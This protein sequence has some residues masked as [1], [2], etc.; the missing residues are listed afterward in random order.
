MVDDESKKI[1]LDIFIVTNLDQVSVFEGVLPMYPDI[2][3]VQYF[4]DGDDK[5]L[6]IAQRALLSMNCKLMTVILNAVHRMPNY[7]S[8]GGLIAHAGAK[9]NSPQHDHYKSNFVEMMNL[10]LPYSEIDLS[11]I[12]KLAYNTHNIVAFDVMNGLEDK[13]NTYVQNEQMAAM[14]HSI[15][16]SGVDFNLVDDLMSM[17]NNIYHKS[18]LS[19]STISQND[20]IMPGDLQI[21]QKNSS[22]HGEFEG[23][24]SES[25]DSGQS[26]T[27]D[28]NNDNISNNQKLSMPS[29]ARLCIDNSQA[30]LEYLCNNVVNSKYI[31]FALRG[32][33]Q[34]HHYFGK[35]TSNDI[36]LGKD[37]NT[38]AALITKMCKLIANKNIALQ[39][40]ALINVT[41]S[42]GVRLIQD[43]MDI[44]LDSIITIKDKCNES[45]IFDLCKRAIKN[46]YKPSFDKLIAIL[47]KEHLN[48]HCITYEHSDRLIDGYTLLQVACLNKRADMVQ[49]LLEKDGIDV[50]VLSADRKLTALQMVQESLGKSTKKALTKYKEIEEILLNYYKEHSYNI[51]E[52]VNNNNEIV[53]NVVEDNALDDDRVLSDADEVHSQNDG[54]NKRKLTI[55]IP[56][57]SKIRK[58]NSD[59]NGNTN[60]SNDNEVDTGTDVDTSSNNLE[61]FENQFRHENV[62]LKK[63]NALLKQ[64]N[65]EIEQQWLGEKAHYASLENKYAALEKS[66]NE[67]DRKYKE[68]MRKKSEEDVEKQKLETNIVKLEQDNKKLS[69]DLESAKQA[70]AQVHDEQALIQKFKSKITE[71]DKTIKTLSQKLQAYAIKIATFEVQEVIRS[72]D[73][74]NDDFNVDGDH[75]NI[76]GSNNV[77]DNNT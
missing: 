49:I 73:N 17:N 8:M 18:T 67:I 48:M 37:P 35:Y 66:K 24:D 33:M 9:E 68:I 7:I 65:D 23:Y 53:A 25:E 75:D 6:N 74:T 55:K 57:S 51:D 52:S 77:F 32:I 54:G 36:L 44:I 63:L 2:V 72:C 12:K 70:R 39:K 10:M 50:K 42:T 46:G 76:M 5:S 30:A 58:T 11:G 47:K 69:E 19:N 31:I 29:F 34:E 21:S 28:N 56:I 3:D 71:Q 15:F 27:H 38:R 62:A 61:G 43:D 14:E 64:H 4:M 41:F 26:G 13:Y 40:N 22:M 45:L 20:Q 1:L 60:N 59:S 16:D